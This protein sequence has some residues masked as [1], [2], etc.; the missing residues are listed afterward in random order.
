MRSRLKGEND[1]A[2]GEN[3]ENDWIKHLQRLTRW[4][5]STSVPA[6]ADP[7][8]GKGWGDGNGGGRDHVHGAPGPIAGAGLPILAVG[9]GAYWLVRRYRRKSGTA[10]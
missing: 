6:L 3:A 10:S 9:Y 2:T 4:S 1:H 5:L 8:K 7:G